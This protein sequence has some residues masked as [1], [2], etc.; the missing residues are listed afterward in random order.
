MSFNDEFKA[1]FSEC[2]SAFGETAVIAGVTK[3]VIAQNLTEGENLGEGGFR[4]TAQIGFHI[5]R[6]EN[7]EPA[8]GATVI[9]GGKTLRIA[10]IESDE[11][12]HYLIC[13]DPNAR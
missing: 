7:P 11:C 10:S 13:Y 9:Y 2:M 3:T 6:D 4:S 8:L 1:G 5:V 12:S